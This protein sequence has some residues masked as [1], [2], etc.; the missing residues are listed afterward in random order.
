MYTNPKVTVVIPTKE[1]EDKIEKCL[2]AIFKQTIA[3]YEVIVVDGHSKDN[4][5]A[6]AQ[7]F[8]AKIIYEEYKTVGGA[9]KIGVENAN[10]QYVAFTDSDCIPKEDWLE[11]LLNEFEKGIVGIGGATVN[12]GKGIW[13]ESISLA[14][15]SFLGSANSVQDRLLPTKKYVKA[16][17]GCNSIY[18]ID[19]VL[20]VGNFNPALR[21]NED[22]DI[23]RK[24]QSLGKILY[25]PNA[26]VYHNQDR[27]LK[28]FAKRMYVFG[29]GR[30][31]NKLFDL[32]VIPPMLALLALLLLFTSIK[33][34]AIMIS[35]YICILIV[36]D[37]LLFKSH[38]KLLYLL[39]VPFIFILE[40]ISYTFGFWN[41]IAK[42]FSGELK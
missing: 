18:K 9:R 33:V 40:H 4:T 37:I 25:T 5:V 13:K 6:K 1:A 39:S 3:P 2:E 19:D 11:N 32:Q 10:G 7:K 36:F 29:R 35:F 26:V 14:L 22:T 8:S 21:M 41:G 15:N 23:S 17:S 27:G 20:K 28:D 31:Q 30:A 12:I 34:F 16:I 24:M 38:K 42:L